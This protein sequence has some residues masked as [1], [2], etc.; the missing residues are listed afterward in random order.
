MTSSKKIVTDLNRL[1]LKN[2]YVYISSFIT[3]IVD[4]YLD[5]YQDI[6]SDLLIDEASLAKPEYFLDD[7][8]KSL[9][10]FSYITNVGS[11]YI[12]FKVPSEDTYEFN[13]RLKF[14]ELLQNGFVGTYYELS[15]NDYNALL[16]RKDLSKKLVEILYSLPG[17]LSE[18][19]TMD[20]DFY[21]LD[22][23]YNVHEIFQKILGKNLIIFPFSNFP[24][25]DL[26]SR[27]EEY[28][29]NS[30]DRM[31]PKIIEQAIL[32]LKRGV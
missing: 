24:P 12:K 1:I 28:F 16:L 26:F 32:D 17:I 27:G 11:N 9:T 21:L 19:V 29:N 31:T 13:G 30:K 8:K 5:T 23:K 10:I 22:E 7:Y 14:L 4:I 6:F 25:V 18:D 20:L 3:E 2:C 15:I